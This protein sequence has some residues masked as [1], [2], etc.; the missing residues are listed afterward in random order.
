MI[1]RAMWG[2]GRDAEALD[3][4]S[5]FDVV[6]EPLDPAWASDE[7]PT[8]ALR[9]DVRVVPP[10]RILDR[11][12][13][14]SR[15]DACASLGLDP[16]KTNV[17]VA[18]GAGNNFDLAGITRRIIDRLNGRSDIGLAVAEWQ[19]A[20]DRLDLSDSIARL[21]GYPF[22]QYLSAFDFA[23]AAPGYNTFCEHLAAGLPT[24]WVPNENEQMDRQ[25]DRAR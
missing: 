9:S 7:G 3:R 22:A 23:V 18:A 17:L 11:K 14:P 21:S 4:A 6:V 12:E 10:V 1:R 24:L 19:I 16:S 2:A 25:I 5:A 13:V 8:V 15:Q 20:N